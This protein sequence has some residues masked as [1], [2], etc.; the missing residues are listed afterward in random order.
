MG[1]L[2]I[3]FITR[4]RRNHA[5]EHATVHVLNRR[6][7]AMH[8]VGWSTPSGFYIY[9][10][11]P[12]TDV[13]HAVNEALTRLRRGESHLAVH[14]RCGTNL[15]TAGTLVGLISFL[16]MLPGDRHS[17]R[18]R[19]PLVVLLSTLALI[20]AQP[21]GLVVQEHITTDAK[22]DVAIT[23]IERGTS[24]GAPVHRVQVQ[25]KAEH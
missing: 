9:G 11:V 10:H 14:P 20:V 24:R 22:V 19:L 23:E 3:P 8:I 2:D 25:H 16:T 7:P 17:R 13:Q 5:I 18:E 4:T 1:L 15:V 21:L 6:H 12:T